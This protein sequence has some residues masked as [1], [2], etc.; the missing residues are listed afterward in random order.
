MPPAFP[1]RLICSEATQPGCQTAPH[2]AGNATTSGQRA[3]LWMHPC[4]P[5]FSAGLLHK[6]GANVPASFPDQVISSRTVCKLVSFGVFIWRGSGH[7]P[8]RASLPAV[9]HGPGTVNVCADVCPS[10]A[11]LWPP[12]GCSASRR[13]AVRSLGHHTAPTHSQF[14][15]LCSGLHYN[16]ERCP[17]IP[18]DIFIIL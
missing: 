4:S 17:E 2:V 13:A 1:G 10:G 12:R 6:A 18:L 8:R 15:C 14:R 3:S 5:A 9:Q 16:T 11:A 7:A